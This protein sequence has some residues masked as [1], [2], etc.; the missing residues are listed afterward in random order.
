MKNKLYKDKNGCDMTWLGNYNFKGKNTNQTYVKCIRYMGQVY[1]PYYNNK[2]AGEGQQTYYK[3]IND[4]ELLDAQP[5]IQVSNKQI[6]KIGGI[7]Y[8]D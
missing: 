7:L 4:I 6:E 1:V 2:S 5:Q 3:F 8:E